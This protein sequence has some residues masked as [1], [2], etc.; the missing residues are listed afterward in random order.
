[1]TCIFGRLH[2]VISQGLVTSDG[3]HPFPRAFNRFALKKFQEV[4]HQM[5]GRRTGRSKRSPFVSDAESDAL[6]ADIFADIEKLSSESDSD[7][8]AFGLDPNTIQKP[9]KRQKKA[10]I[11]ST[12]P[13]AGPSVMISLPESGSDAAIKDVPLVQ[14]VLGVRDGCSEEDP[15]YYVKWT[16]KSYVHCTW[17][18]R[19]ELIE[20]SGGE[21]AIRKFVSKQKKNGMTTSSSIPSLLTLGNEE[22]ASSWMTVDRVIGENENGEFYVKWCGLQYEQ[23]TWET[24]ADV[25]DLDNAIERF[26]KRKMRSNPIRILKPRA[27]DPRT[28]V[29]VATPVKSHDGQELRDYQMHGFNW[30]RWCWYQHCNSILADEMGLGKTV[31]IVSVLRDISMN[32]GITGPFLVLAPLST[33]AHWQ[34]EF[35]RWSDLNAVI[36]HGSPA[37][38]EIIQKYEMFV[39]NQENQ[40]IPDRVAFDVLISNYETFMSDPEVFENIQWRYVV[41]DEGHRLKNHTGKCYQQLQKLYCEHCT[42]LTG[43][44]IQNNV[45]ELW[46]LLHL[47]HPRYFSSL[48]DFMAKFGVMD[49]ANKVKELQKLI[50]PLLLRRKK[51]DVDQTIAAKEETIIE[52]ELTRIQKTYYKL[53]LHKNASTLLSNITGGTLPS[54]LNLM[55]QLRKVCNHPFLLKGVTES[56]EQQFAEKLGGTVQDEE[57]QLK[58]LV[59]SSGKMIL[60]DKLLAKLKE[61]GHKVL[62]F[63]QMVKVL[64]ILEEYCAMKGYPTERID[65]HVPETERQLSI[66]K[67]SNDDAFV[68][69]LCTRAGGVGINLTAADTVIIYDSDWNP[70]NDLQAESRCHRIGQTST[71]KVYRL[72]TRNT[73]EFEMLDRAS[74]KLGLDHA[75]LDGGQINPKQ[76]PMAAKEIEKL[77]RSGVYD[78]VN[79]DDTEIENFC[80]ENI[81]QILQSRTTSFKT[82]VASGN[83]VFSKAKFETDTDDATSQDFWKDAISKMMVKSD[84]DLGDRKCKRQRKPVYHEGSDDEKWIKK[85]KRAPAAPLTPKAVHA[86]IMH[87]GYRGT[88]AE[89]VLLANAATTMEE[90]LDEDDENLLKHILGMDDLLEQTEEMQATAAKFTPPLTEFTD[91]KEQLVKRVLLYFHIGQVLTSVQGPVSQWPTSIPGSDPLTDY[92]ILFGVHKNGLGNLQRVLDDVDYKPTKQFSDKQIHRICRNLIAALLPGNEHIL[93]FPEFLSPPEWRQVHEDIFNRASMSNDELVSLFQTLTALG[94]PETTTDD[95]NT[96]VDWERVASFSNLSCLKLDAFRTEG[97]LLLAVANDEFDPDSQRELSERL[98][99][100]GNRVWISR[101]RANHRDLGRIRRFVSKFTDDQKEHILKMKKWDAG[102]DWWNSDMDIAL[103]RALSDYGLI[104]VATW[105][106]D[107]DRPFYAHLSDSTRTELTR[108]ADL[109]KE[110]GKPQKPKEAGD[111]DAIFNDKAR[112]SRALAVIQFVD[113]RE[114]KARARAERELDDPADEPPLAFTEL[115]ELPIE[116]GNQLTVFDLGEFTDEATQYPVGYKCHRLYFSILDPCSKTW[117]EGTTEINEEGNFQYKVTFLEEPYTVFTCHTSSGVWEKVIQEVQRVRGTMGLSV[118]KFTTVSGPFMYGFSH[119]TIV[120]CFRL[121]AVRDSDE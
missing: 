66:D 110:K 86:K 112:M 96:T 108:L 94:F 18:P 72:V 71:V 98:G 14:Q 95:G 83:S 50:Q 16:G 24:R 34:K 117:Y 62:I 64:D 29:S 79:D 116:L 119:P 93:E 81:D 7:D 23:C 118:R 70:Q 121:M 42:L 10:P 101:L 3:A 19:S 69:L 1:M 8:F 89:K 37:S 31:Q 6:L 88:I 12:L 90:T 80:S 39:Y 54:L 51:T 114:S 36:Y 107:P 87:Q 25:K 40:R 49:D 44:P 30:L 60:V 68:F 32:H 103:L 67:F 57:V 100:Y 4:R 22:I 115:P 28:F 74:K 59:E 77:L 48:S 65:G 47:L 102:P 21:N 61:G 113:V 78:M 99:P 92:A 35:E 104:Y 111:L 75:I 53:L 26:K 46:S 45:E 55:M 9:P 97:E 52:V 63:S 106:I 20:I 33:L 17:M 27:V 56:I 109:E 11:F 41:L 85:R 38:K 105:L 73:Y 91:K 43:T 82:N 58:A 15:V 84:E 5:S 2:T 120:N 76:R 13:E